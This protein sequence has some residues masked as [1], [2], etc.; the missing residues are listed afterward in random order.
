DRREVATPTRTASAH[1]DAV[2]L[3]KH[4]AACA[5]ARSGSVQAHGVVTAQGPREWLSFHDPERVLT[6]KLFLLPDTDCLAWDQMNSATGLRAIDCAS[7]EPP[8]HDTFLRRA[9]ARFGHRWQ[10]RLLVFKYQQFPWMQS[11][12]AHAPLRI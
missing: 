3:L 6:S 4:P 9:L 8:A 11:L 10:A 5:L 2:M 12:D 1:G 7:C